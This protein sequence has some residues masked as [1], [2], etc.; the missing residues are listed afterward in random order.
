MTKN[1]PKILTAARTIAK[2]PKILDEEKI[3][4]SPPDN[5][6]MIAPTMITGP[7]F[8]VLADRIE[9]RLAIFSNYIVM[10]IITLSFIVAAHMYVINMITVAIFSAAIGMVASANHPFRTTMAARLGNKEQLSS[11]IAITTLNFNL[12]RLVGPAIGGILISQ[13]GPIQTLWVTSLGFL[14]MI[15]LIQKISI[16]PRDTQTKMEQRFSD[17]LKEGFLFTKKTL[18]YFSFFVNHMLE[19]RFHFAQVCQ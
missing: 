3:T 11:I 5:A 1:P 4:P 12:S 19:F 10:L 8:G 15:F 18:L 9:I 16:R 6:A 7:L 13:I 17:A 2:N 14:P